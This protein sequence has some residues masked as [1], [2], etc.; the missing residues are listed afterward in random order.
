MLR[1]PFQ[2]HDILTLFDHS[3]DGIEDPESDV[4]KWLAA[5]DMRPAAWFDAFDNVEPRDGRRPFRR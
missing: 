3:L 4:N 1:S 2:D 5:G